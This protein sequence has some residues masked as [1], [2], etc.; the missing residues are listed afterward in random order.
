MLYAAAFMSA[1]AR[2]LAVGPGSGAFELIVS[3]LLAYSV[4]RIAEPIIKYRHDMK[5]P[6]IAITP[7]VGVL[8][9]ILKLIVGI[10][11]YTVL[12]TATFG[13]NLVASLG[14]LASLMLFQVAMVVVLDDGE[15]PVRRAYAT[16]R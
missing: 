4:L 9:L 7:Y 8:G 16:L 14:S 10:R 15:R 2:A 3:G 5:F 6:D 13:G 1:V 12:N 11:L